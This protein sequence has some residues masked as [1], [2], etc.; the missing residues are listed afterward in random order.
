MSYRQL[1]KEIIDIIQFTAHG[2]NFNKEK[3]GY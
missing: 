3:A 1:G 2:A